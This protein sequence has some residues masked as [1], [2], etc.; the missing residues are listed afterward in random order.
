MTR[1]IPGGIGTSPYGGMGG[2][3][4]VT[5]GYTFLNT[6]DVSATADRIMREA[7]SYYLIEVA[8]P[9]VG[10]KWICACST[11]ATAGVA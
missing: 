7:G 1:S 3:A 5:G 2:F 4:R 11:C 9:P 6:N 8:D 10:R